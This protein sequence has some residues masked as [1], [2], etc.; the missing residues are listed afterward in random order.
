MG[1]QVIAIFFFLR[2][3]GDFLRLGPFSSA[4][5]GIFCIFS[6]LHKQIQA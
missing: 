5:W 3:S 4:F 1:C 2:T 6:R